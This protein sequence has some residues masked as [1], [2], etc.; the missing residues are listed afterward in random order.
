MKNIDGKYYINPYYEKEI[1]VSKEEA[2]TSMSAQ[3]ETSEIDFEEIV[4][5]PECECVCYIYKVVSAVESLKVFVS[6]YSGEI[7]KTVGVNTLARSSI[8][9]T[10]GYSASS[11]NIQIIIDGQEKTLPVTKYTSTNGGGSFYALSDANVS[12][13]Y[14]T[15][16]KNK[17]DYTYECYDTILNP[18]DPSDF[19]DQDAIKAYEGLL[20][21]YNF[22]KDSDNFGV[23]IDG[24]KNK[25]GSR[26]DLIAIV[27]FDRNYNNAGYVEPAYSNSKYGY[28]IFGDGDSIKNKSFVNGVDVIGHEY[29]H[30][31]TASIVDLEYSKESGALTEAISD[32][33]GAAI[34]GN[35]ISSQYFWQLGEDV[36][37]DTSTPYIRNMANPS[38]TRCVSNYSQI[39][40]YTQTLYVSEDNDYGGVHYI[41]TLPTYATYLM[42]QKAPTLFTQENILKLWYQTIYHLTSTSSITDFCAGMISAA[43]E[44]EFDDEMTAVIEYAFASVGVPGY[45]GIRTWNNNS[46]TI[47]DGAGTIASPY[48][49]K[50]VADLASVAYYINNTEN[51]Y[52]LT[53]RY[54]LECDLNLSDVNWISIGTESRQFNG[55]FNGDSHKISG[56]NLEG[57]EG[58]LFN[59]LFAYVGENGYIYDLNIAS[60]QTTTNA[61]YVGAIAGIM[62]GAIS[63]CSSS[64]SISGKNVGGLVGQMQSNSGG[65]KIANCFVK[66]NLTGEKVGGLVC[67]FATSKNG[68]NIY[69]SAYIT[70]SYYQGNI[71]AQTAGGLVAE[72]NGLYMI[73]NLVYA[74]FASN[75]E[76]NVFGGLIAK[77]YF[78]NV[79]DQSEATNVYNYILSNFVYCALSTDN[80]QFGFIVG[81][82]YGN[83]VG[84]QTLISKNIVKDIEDVEFVYS[85]ENGAGLIL[86]DNKK[87]QDEIYTG[88]FDFDNLNY[89]SNQEWTIFPVSESFDFVGTF[90]INKN[91]MPTFT[92]MEFWLGEAGYA[93]AGGDGSEDNP[94]QISTAEQ[95]A[96]LSSFMA[97][98]LYYDR[99]ASKY[100]I[101]TNDI[102]LSGK[103][104]VGI[105]CKRYYFQN[106]KVQANSSYSKTYYF[107]GT[108]DGNGHTIK[109]M[110]T[111]RLY[112]I[113]GQSSDGQNFLI[114][115]FMPGLF[116]Y[117]C[118][119]NS[120]VPTIKNLILENVEIT[121]SCT[122]AVVSHAYVSLNLENI[123]VMNGSIKSSDIA[124]GLVGQVDGFTNLSMAS[125]VIEIKDCY[126]CLDISGNVVGGAVGY[127][128]NGSSSKSSRMN[129]INF[130]GKNNISV[131]GTEKEVIYNGTDS[132]PDY[133]KAIAGNVVG[134]TMIKN[135]SIINTIVIGDIVSYTK[136][137]YLGAYVG[138]VG[139]GDPFTGQ[140]INIEIDACKHFGDMYYILNKDITVGGTIVGGT[141]ATLLKMIN[142]SIKDKTYTNQNTS[143]VYHNNSMFININ[144]E[145]NNSE[146]E[147][148]EGDFEFYS[149]DYFQNSVYFNTD[150]VW[151]NEDIERFGFLVLFKLYDGT[152][153]KREVVKDGQDATPPENPTLS[154]TAAYDFE[155][156][157]YDKDF[158]NVS[159]DLVVYALFEATARKYEITYLDDNGNVIEKLLLDYGQLINQDIQFAQKQSNIFIRYTFMGFGEKGQTV[160]G[161]ATVGP[162]Y[163]VE[164]TSA[165]IIMIL[166]I[167]ACIGSVVYVLTKRKSN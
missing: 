88:D 6:A 115:E 71:T 141:H 156:V 98:D 51:D 102:D 165:G 54:K 140:S 21:C 22:Y 23:S 130:L 155:F 100:Y 4:I 37:L 41:C 134:I 63:G 65:Q 70:G 24:I 133:Y 10:S 109:N 81:N 93:F 1:K 56:L 84:G 92:D 79:I 73:N 60:G 19:N 103:V 99:Y 89:F 69:E 76:E 119:T 86:E 167:V 105:G 162:V 123:K 128:T 50:S 43:E 95:L 161:D 13:I 150:Y 146:D 124:G 107:T 3:Y 38:A 80:L 66:A 2:E 32:I 91:Q 8:Y 147:K 116:S 11:D 137:S 121:G 55:Y 110:K 16:G 39:S 127:V 138:C 97:S 35:D 48:L 160:V 154:S 120:T 77:L 33:F 118:P 113:G 164:I 47:L 94:Y 129:I 31:I 159:R 27:H 30:A 44:L 17:N 28:F 52:Y 29:Q 25:N 62:L 153:I 12:K 18:S 45:T 163:K 46:L 90:K 136:N 78:D 106:N 57:Q 111:M 14:M 151:T 26:I 142:I 72:G 114:Y 87:S 157:G 58:D 75:S 36:V 135:L 152:I 61:E 101:L 139:A 108:F 143:A 117:T 40:Q 5:L 7:V 15:N 145:I 104:W 59:G 83:T 34:E 112:S 148:G 132:Y 158:T 96:T 126:T 122:G 9:D 67:T 42:Y 20:K 74:N 53:A 68:N 166:A 149:D 85:A 131:D 125:P 49:I 144:S 82:F 64:L